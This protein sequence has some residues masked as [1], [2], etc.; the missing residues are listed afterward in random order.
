MRI[1]IFY[2]LLTLKR[3]KECS[4]RT[5][6]SIKYKRS[7]SNKIPTTTKETK[8]QILGPFLGSPQAEFLQEMPR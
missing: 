6:T 3:E 4:E 8:P 5:T 7:R 1:F 2:Q